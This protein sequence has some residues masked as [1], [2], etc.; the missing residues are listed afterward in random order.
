V[1]QSR[2]SVPRF[3]A[4]R[5]AL[6]ALAQTVELLLHDEE[7]HFGGPQPH[8]H[9]FDARE[10]QAEAGASAGADT[11]PQQDGD[12][13]AV[14]DGQQQ[15]G[16]Q[17]GAGAEAEAAWRDGQAEAQPQPQG[18]AG[19]KRAGAIGC[20]ITAAAAAA[21]APWPCGSGGARAAPEAA[22]EPADLQQGQLAVAGVPGME[23]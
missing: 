13:P 1:Q 7:Q 9:L 17:P 11:A 4:P 18:A 20:R 16:L 21:A 3:P 2:P 23:A 10:Q 12:G 22:Q 5:S 15:A 14:H 19:C 6:R 8:A